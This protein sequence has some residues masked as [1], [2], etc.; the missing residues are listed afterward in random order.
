M[1]NDRLERVKE[2]AYHTENNALGY[3][4]TLIDRKDFDYLVGEAEE[5][6]S[7]KEEIKRLEMLVLNSK[8]ASRIEELEKV[9]KQLKD[10]IKAR[11]N[12]SR[13]IGKIIKNFY[14][15]GYFG[16]RYDLEGSTI[17]D[18]GDRHMMISLRNGERLMTHFDE[19]WDEYTDKMVAEWIGEAEDDSDNAN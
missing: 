7:L 4:T 10:S 13:F 3:E 1:A 17:V 15:N 8:D 6:T 2:E 5:A 12:K 14:C 18:I 16:R 11:K 9:N 19:E